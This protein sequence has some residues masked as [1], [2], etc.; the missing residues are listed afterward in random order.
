[1]FFDIYTM[2][3]RPC[4]LRYHDGL[5]LLL[6]QNMVFWDNDD[7]FKPSTLMHRFVCQWVWVCGVLNPYCSFRPG[8]T[9]RPR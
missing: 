3:P 9:P 5:R 2:Q 7:R 1:M 4:Y 8:R 6:M